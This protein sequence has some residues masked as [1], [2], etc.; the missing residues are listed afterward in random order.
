[1]MAQDEIRAIVAA[2][3]PDSDVTVTDL[4]GE[5]DH[6]QVTVVSPRF[7]GRTLIERHQMVQTPLRAAVDDGRI[8]ALTL[9]TFTP[10]QWKKQLR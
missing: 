10:E 3:I 9:K 5:L 4:T 1:M 2:A 7:E 8:H 6:F